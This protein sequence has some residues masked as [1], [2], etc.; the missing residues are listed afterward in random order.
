MAYLTR[1]SLMRATGWTRREI[2]ELLSAGLPHQVTGQGR[3]SEIQVDVDAALAWF[4]TWLL[5]G[6]DANPAKERLDE[7]RAQKLELELDE[8][9][10]TLVDRS[11]VNALFHELG[12]RSR[13]ALEQWPAQV[14][15]E[16][17]GELGVDRHKMP[18]ALERRVREHLARTREELKLVLRR[19][20]AA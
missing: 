6:A 12:K 11:E 14:A 7:L 15:A 16:M 18:R 19:D 5:D 4:A 2:D 17:G 10:G 20:R 1:A 3:G 13:E 8:R 9:R